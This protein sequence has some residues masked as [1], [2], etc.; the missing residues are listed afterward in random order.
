MVNCQVA[1][2]WGLFF[3]ALLGWWVHT[4]FYQGSWWPTSAPI[5]PVT[6]DSFPS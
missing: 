2:T 6:G 3:L 1:E 5:P 4:L